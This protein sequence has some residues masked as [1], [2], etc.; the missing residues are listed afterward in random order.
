MK[1]QTNVCPLCDKVLK[2]HQVAKV[3]VYSCH[4]HTNYGKSH[5]EVEY[6]KHATIQHVYV[7]DWCIDNFENMTKSRIYKR[8]LRTGGEKWLL[9][10]DSFYF[11]L[12]TEENMLIKLNKLFP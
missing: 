10:A 1:F 6:D 5:Y 3:N 9:V 2:F 8:E 7:G 12:D 4:A 11:S